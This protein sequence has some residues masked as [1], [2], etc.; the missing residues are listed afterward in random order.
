MKKYLLASVL[1]FLFTGCYDDQAILSDPTIHPVENAEDKVVTPPKGYNRHYHG[2][3]YYDDYY[4]YNGYYYCG[5]RH[6]RSSRACDDE[7][8]ASNGPL[9]YQNSREGMA[10]READAL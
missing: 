5:D 10:A 8:V 9:T 4:F 1:V 7:L 2:Y 3:Y 6:T